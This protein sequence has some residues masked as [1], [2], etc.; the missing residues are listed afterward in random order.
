MSV[1]V[2]VFQGEEFAETKNSSDVKARQRASKTDGNKD[3]E[4]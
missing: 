3:M 4:K 1:Y 2:I